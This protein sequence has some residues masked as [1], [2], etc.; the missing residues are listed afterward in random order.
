M[1][2]KRKYHFTEEMDAEIRE[3]YQNHVM[4]KAV[5]HK[6]YVRDLANK[7]GIPRWRVSRRAC[8]LGVLPVQKKEPNWTERELSILQQNSHLSTA[9]IQIR[10]KKYGFHRSESAIIQ[11]RKRMR[12]PANLN[13]NSALAV[14]H[15]FGIDIHCVTRWIKNGW[16]KANRR[17]TARTPAQGGDEW[18]IKDKWIRDFIIDSVAVID[19]RKIDKYWLVDLLANNK[20]D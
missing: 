12:Y 1:A 9:R 10:L 13:G 3:L 15:C 16:L 6:G 5:Q 4:M 2:G 8:E 11:K 18:Y 7:F 17:G 20:A 19:F 14:A